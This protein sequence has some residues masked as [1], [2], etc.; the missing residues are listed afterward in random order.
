[1]LAV[2]C[3]VWWVLKLMGRSSTMQL[4]LAL[5]T[6]AIQGQM[7]RQAMQ[8]VVLYVFCSSDLIDLCCLCCS[9]HAVRHA[10]SRG[11]WSHFLR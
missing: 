11:D 1:V 8:V 10:A 4:V 3:M 9:W 6:S 5:K 7:D 2:C